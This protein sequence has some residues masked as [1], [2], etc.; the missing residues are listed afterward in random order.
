LMGKIQDPSI[1]FTKLVEH[2]RNDLSLSYKVLRYVNSAYVGIPNRVESIEHAACM[3][4]IDRIRTWST[5][6]IMASGKTQATEILV[7][8]LVRA[9]MCEQL[10]Q[11]LGSHSPEKYFTLGLL[12]VL[13]ALYELPI[14]EIL[15]K[16]SL[17]DDV[18]EALTQGTGK[19]GLVLSCVKAYEEG[20]W[21]ELKHLQL[22][23]SIIR[24][25]Y[26]EAIDWANHFSP[27]IA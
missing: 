19:M 23:P 17:A 10:G 11:K 14:A 5:L 18:V 7:I 3:V 15:D 16:L 25:V 24:D 4:G 27:M 9:K 6:I 12:S 26:L 22:E 21:M 1:P 13:E 2:I 8:A 20:E